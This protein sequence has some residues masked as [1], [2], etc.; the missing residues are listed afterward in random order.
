M[1]PQWQG[2]PADIYALYPPALTLSA[3]V[4][5]FVDFLWRHFADE[6]A[7]AVTRDSK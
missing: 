4:R 3:R 6:A 5:L 7:G 1:L 2:T